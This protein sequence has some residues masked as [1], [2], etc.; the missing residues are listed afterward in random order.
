VVAGAVSATHTSPPVPE[1]ADYPFTT[2]VPNLGMVDFEG[3]G[4]L[5]ADIPGLIEGASEGKGLGDEFLRHIERT[6]VLLHLVEAGAADPVAD[7]TQIQTELKHYKVDLAAKP[8]LLVITKSE[9]VIP[10]QLSAAQASLRQAAPK[11]KMFV[12]SAQ[13]HQGLAQ[14]LRATQQ[15]VAAAHQAREQAE[16]TDELPVITATDLPDFWR[17]EPAG[18]NA[19]RLTGD[20][21]EGFARRTDFES[22]DAVARLQDILRK[23]GVAKELRR[24]A[25]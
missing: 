25:P 24:Q 6:S 15:L 11:T 22:P 1:I 8:Q 13:E 14:L 12:I 21:L 23:S 4:F 10:E 9:T 5:V 16:A 19:W 3:S 7:Y 17:L 2:L 20:R 18:D